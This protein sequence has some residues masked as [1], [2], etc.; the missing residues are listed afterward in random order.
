MHLQSLLPILDTFIEALWRATQKE[1]EH[2]LQTANQEAANQ[3]QASNN[4]F[5]LAVANKVSILP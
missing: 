4:H 3:E 2:V 1:Y 5:P